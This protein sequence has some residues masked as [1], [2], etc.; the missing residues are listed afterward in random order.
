MSASVGFFRAM[1]YQGSTPLSR[2]R[3][4]QWRLSRY[5]FG[6]GLCLAGGFVYWLVW[7]LMA[8]YFQPLWVMGSGEEILRGLGGGGVIGVA[9]LLGMTWLF[10]T[11]YATRGARLY[12]RR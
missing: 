4:G 5:F 6:S 11:G 9:L 3:S 7:Y 10:M 2:S 1:K 8:K 12:E